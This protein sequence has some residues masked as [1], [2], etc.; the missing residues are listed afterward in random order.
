MNGHFATE[1]ADLGKQ[2]WRRHFQKSW[3]LPFWTVGASEVLQEITEASMPHFTD[4]FR[5]KAT[6]K[7]R[8]KAKIR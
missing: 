7:P 4:P 5:P 1:V 2:D 6:S 3:F 8:S